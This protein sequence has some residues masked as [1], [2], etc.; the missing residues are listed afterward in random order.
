MLPS[1][2]GIQVNRH[3]DPY[4]TTSIMESKRFFL[5]WLNYSWRCLNNPNLQAIQIRSFTQ[6]GVNISQKS[7]ET[8]K[9]I[10]LSKSKSH[11]F[12]FQGRCITGG[13]SVQG[14]LYDLFTALHHQQKVTGH[15]SH[16]PTTI[17]LNRGNSDLQPSRHTKNQRH[18]HSRRLACASRRRP[19]RQ[20]HPTA[21]NGTPRKQGSTPMW[22]G[23][24]KTAMR[25]LKYLDTVGG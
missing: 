12:F 13:C 4:T 3:K 15:A 8:T 1:Y 25:S 20:P 7:L 5:S 19:S 6:V 9:E 17:F 21:G 14:F 23:T 16:Q 18:R 11:K 2:V 10:F 22:V 24:R